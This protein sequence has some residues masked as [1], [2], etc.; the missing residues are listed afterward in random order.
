MKPPTK[1]YQ[2]IYISGPMTGLPKHN[3]PAFNKAAD[4]LRKKGYKVINPAELDGTNKTDMTW[5]SCLRRD[6]KCI[7][8]KCFAVATLP[9]WKKS[10][11]ALLEIHVAR[12]LNMPI[13]PV[14]YYL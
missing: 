3:Y 7:V 6:L 10:K 13:H 14:K 11:G 8:T 9:G 5:V 4:A 1:K 2:Y 12:E